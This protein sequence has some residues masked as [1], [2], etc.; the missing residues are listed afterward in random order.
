MKQNRFFWTSRQTCSSDHQW[1]CCGKHEQHLA[2]SEELS[3]SRNTTLLAMKTFQHLYFLSK[4]RSARSPIPMMCNFYRSAIKN[5]LNQ[6]PHDVVRILLKVPPSHHDSIDCW[7]L[8]PFTPW[9]AQH[10]PHLE[11]LL[12][13][14]WPYTPTTQLL[15]TA[16][17][18]GQNQQLFPSG[19]QDVH[20][21]LLC[22]PFLLILFN[23]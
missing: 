20:L 14:G 12:H 7:H 17:S 2:V 4:L 15:H 11:I 13:G 23:T 1:C 22:L 6:L 10:T 16:E 5:T 8:L 21:S 18:S 19:R 9:P 3:W